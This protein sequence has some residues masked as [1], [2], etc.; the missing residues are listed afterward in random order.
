MTHAHQV[1]AR[2]PE[3][4]ARS[5]PGLATAAVASASAPSCCGLH[6]LTERALG[7]CRWP[8]RAASWI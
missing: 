5:C 6:K 7:S 1:R 2:S 8:L 4:L 3:G